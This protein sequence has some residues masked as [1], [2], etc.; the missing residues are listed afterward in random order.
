VDG[1]MIERFIY[2]ILQQ[3]GFKC[4]TAEELFTALYLETRCKQ[5]SPLHWHR[6]QQGAKKKE[7]KVGLSASAIADQVY[8]VDQ[9]ILTPELWGLQITCNSAELDKKIAQLKGTQSL[10]VALGIKKTV[11]MVVN[12]PS[13]EFDGFSLLTQAQT[14]RIEEAIYECF[15]EPGELA[16]ST[17][18]LS[19]L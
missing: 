13:L 14:D 10:R 4:P 1:F 2:L 6:C 8:K 3:M 17:L 19:W 5:I 18:D 15:E 12:R 11:L 7:T 9:F 16:I